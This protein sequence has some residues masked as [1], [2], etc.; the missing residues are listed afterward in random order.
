M[1]HEIRVPRLGWSMEEGTFVGWLKQPGQ[2]VAAGEPLYELEGDKAL[3]VIEAVD[4][5]L[6]DVPDDSPPPGTVVAVGTLLGFLLAAGETR[7][8]GV[9]RQ[10]P[11][12]ASTVGAPAAEVRPAAADACSTNP[13]TSAP[14]EP[15]PVASPAVRRLARERGLDWRRVP[16]AGELG[17]VTVDDLSSTIPARGRLA[18]SLPQLGSVPV[19]TPRARRVAGELGIDWRGLVGSGRGGRIREDDVRQA[20]LRARQGAQTTVGAG[21]DLLTPR[22]RTIAARLRLSRQQTVPVT[23]VTTADATHLVALREHFKSAPLELVPSYAEIFVCLAA[24][25][26]ER[27][28]RLAVCWEGE[29]AAL[30]AVPSDGFHVGLAV[31]TPAGLLV[32]IIR[33]VAAKSLGQVAR[34]AR[35]LVEKARAGRLT[36]A[37]LQGGVITVSNLGSYGIDAFTPVIDYPQISILGLGAIR[38][39]P[40]LAGDGRLVARPR[41]TL[42]L[43]FDHAAVDGAPAAAFLQDLGQ[44][45]AQVVPTLAEG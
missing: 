38:E 28:P 5:G 26:L 18:R 2:P 3:E 15:P 20:A 16:L 44:S 21:R 31:D 10:G 19:S 23:L 25:V 27:H 6:L 41:I 12:A 30:V 13:R 34:E 11:G 36:G 14:G 7:P 33:Q 40:E 9:P 22:R 37:D 35:A 42:S 1:A 4:G 45:L 39:T 24:R 29:P 32:P 8:V 17:R 43:T